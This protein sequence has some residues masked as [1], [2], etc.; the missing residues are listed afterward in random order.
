MTENTTMQAPDEAPELSDIDILIDGDI[1]KE[2]KQ[3]G[4]DEAAPFVLAALIAVKFGAP[5]ELRFSNPA[6]FEIACAV[7]A[8]D[9][10]KITLKVGA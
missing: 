4:P 10:M 5:V 9:G 6:V 3:A 2:L 1:I 8:D 7:F